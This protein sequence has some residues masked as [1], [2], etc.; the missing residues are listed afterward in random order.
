M[1][2]ILIEYRR[3]E[4]TRQRMWVQPEEGQT[5][6]DVVEAMESGEL[7]EDNATQFDCITYQIDDVEHIAG[8]A[9]PVGLL[10]PFTVIMFED[11]DYSVQTYVEC[12]MATDAHAAWD[13]AVKQAN[14]GD[15]VT[16]IGTYD[17]H[18]ESSGDYPK[19]EALNA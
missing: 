8:A 18:L 11:G 10:K 16:E 9:E 14:A 7:E 12:V 15:N 3:K 17:G 1:T 4:I 13:V 2:K 5:P 6:A 19:R